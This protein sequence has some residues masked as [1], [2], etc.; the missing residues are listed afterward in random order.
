MTALL[1][2]GKWSLNSLANIEVVTLLCALF[3]YTFGFAALIP[4]TLFY[5]EETLAWGVHTWVLC[6][7][8]HWNLIVVIFAFLGAKK[9]KDEILPPFKAFVDVILPTIIAV[10]IT[11]LFGVNTSFV[12]AVYACVNSSFDRFFT[13][14]GIIYSRGFILFIVHITCNLVTF[15]TLFYPLSKL[16]FSLKKRLS[17]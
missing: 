5:L 11:F 12:D 4:S 17:L 3:G 2:V 7:L 15:S 14:F 13:Y 6:Y 1:V 16:F 9:R 10:T 8:I